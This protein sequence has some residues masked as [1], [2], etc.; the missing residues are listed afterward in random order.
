MTKTT[1]YQQVQ[2]ALQ[3]YE[4]IDYELP[5]PDEVTVPGVAPIV[6]RIQDQF[7]RLTERLDAFL[8]DATGKTWQ[9]LRMD[10]LEEEEERYRRG[11]KNIL[12]TKT[13]PTCQAQPGDRCRTS[14]G[15]IVPEM[16]ITRR[17]V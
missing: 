13:C 1:G 6:R 8:M 12:A 15:N 17:R 9:E 14:N 5:D 2:E 16:H 3:I 11:S 10:A 4:E 7:E